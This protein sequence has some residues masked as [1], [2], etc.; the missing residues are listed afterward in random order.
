MEKHS[1]YEKIPLYY[2]TLN[3][4]TLHFLRGDF[5]KKLKYLVFLCFLDVASAMPPILEE[6]TPL[7]EKDVNLDL[8]ELKEQNKIARKN[9]REWGAVL[10][11]RPYF[12]PN[13]NYNR[14]SVCKHFDCQEEVIV[15]I[16]EVSSIMDNLFSPSAQSSEEEREKIALAMAIFEHHV[17]KIS[18][19]N[20]WGDTGRNAGRG[21]KG[22]NSLDCI[23]EAFN[24]LSYL[25][26]IKEKL[27]Y[28]SEIQWIHRFGHNA[29]QIKDISGDSFVVDS[30]L[31]NNGYPS[32]ILPREDWK[33][34]KEKDY[35]P[36][37]LEL[38]KK[39]PEEI[40]RYME[41]KGLVHS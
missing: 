16:P 22:S 19:V 6:K 25:I 12:I 23:S 5:M 9:S 8:I 33:K 2:N 41:E 14:L 18:E 39:L 24:T 15:D 13:P 30:W 3:K 40:K 17:G 10:Y 20:T 32:V 21:S 7:V 27:S 38:W 35:I 37:A 11:R 1:W 36:N 28:H 4:K 26:L 29:V 31:L 34:R